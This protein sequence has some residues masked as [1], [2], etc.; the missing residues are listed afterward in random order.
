[1]ASPDRGIDQA[2]ERNEEMTRNLKVLGLAL[3]AMLALGAMTA[4]AA[5]AQQGVLTSD[6]PV[7]LDGVELGVGVNILTAFGG[8][9][10]CQGSTGTGHRA[11]ATPHEFIESGESEF[12]LTPHINQETCVF[13]LLGVSRPMTVTMNG[14]DYV[15]HIGETSETADTYGGTVDLVCPE[16]QAIDEEIFKAGTPRTHE[17]HTNSANLFCTLTVPSQKGLSGP[18]VTTD[19]ANGSLQVKGTITGLKMT[20]HGGAPCGSEQTTENG[21]F[22]ISG[23]VTGTNEAGGATEIAISDE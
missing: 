13:I 2:K 14:C 22:H 5:S 18:L 21:Q 11:G 7:T 15:V 12:T 23:T 9:T 16:G 1:M 8:K 6:R 4:A 3:V 19:T 10:E 20:K 17:A